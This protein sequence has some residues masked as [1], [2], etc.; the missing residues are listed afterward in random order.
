MS[1]DVCANPKFCRSCGQPLYELNKSDGYDCATGKPKLIVLRRCL[2]DDSYTLAFH[3]Y[4]N[5]DL[6]TFHP[7]ERAWSATHIWDPKQYP[8]KVR[9]EAPESATP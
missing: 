6:W 1:D 8:V 9:E 2:V 3:T 7:A 5:H 4:N